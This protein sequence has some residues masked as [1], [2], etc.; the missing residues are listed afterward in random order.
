MYNN[1]KSPKTKEGSI[2]KADNHDHHHLNDDDYDDE[3]AVGG[4]NTH[5]TTQ[6]IAIININ[7]ITHIEKLTSP[8][9]VLSN[10]R[11]RC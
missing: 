2:I 5:K 7:N 11:R 1:K 3:P 4:W 8:S 10:S 6:T 9:S